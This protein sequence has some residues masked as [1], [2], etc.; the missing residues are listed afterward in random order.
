M[1]LLPG[2]ILHKRYRII[3]QLG[4]GDY[5]VVYRAW[6]VHDE[7]DVAV[8]EYL[9]SRLEV[10]KQF[11]AEARR[12]S[13]LKHPQLPAVRDHFALDDV[14]QYLVSDFVDGVDL[15]TL[16]AQYGPLPSELIIEWLQAVC[17]PL[18]YLHEKGTVHLDVKPA[19]IRLAPGGDVYLVDT[20]LPG[21]GIAPGTG[22]YGSPEQQKQS[23]E[24]GP[25]SDIYSLGATLYTLLTE[26]TPAGALQR[27]AGLQETAAAREVNPDVAPYL[28]IVASR[29][30]SLRADAR[31][32][33]VADF[34]QALQ[35]PSGRPAVQHEALR[36]SESLPAPPPSRQIPTSTRRKMQQRTMWGLLGLL[37]VIL[38]TGVGIMFFGPSPLLGGSDEAAT[39]TTQ[40]QV[41]AALTDVAPT[42]TPTPDPTALPTAT[43]EPVLSETGSRLVFMPGGLFRLGNDQGAEDEQPSRMVSLEP[44]YIDETEVTNGAYARCVAAGECDP[45]A[46]DRASFYPDYYGNPEYDDYPVLYVDWYQ[47]QTFCEWRGDRLPSEAEWERAAGFDPER[48]VKSTYPWG[49]DF[50]GTRLNYCDV[51][52]YRQDSDSA[53]DDEYGDTAPVGSYPAGRSPIGA[54]DMLGNVMEWTN[55][56]YDR[57]YYTVA[58]DTNPLGP[59][60]GFSKSVRGGSWLSM[61]DELRVSVRSFYDPE[62]HRA[63]IGFRCAR[64]VE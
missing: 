61:R 31:F 4:R 63:N 21:L 45:P 40:S 39:A 3:N 57:N 53:Y 37:A 64:S 24:V 35:R 49:D 54:Y 47:A 19:N 59:L 9:D 18:A 36:R 32:E 33:T 48:G 17:Q 7:V 58:P 51:N 14:G 43:P 56:W 41:I 38:V 25:A 12:L 50:D 34:S 26:K 1:P 5:G 29:A 6:D 52:C 20:G 46:T 11:R 22:G 62:E 16:L 30:M 60:E 42:V 44:Y 15:Q 55:D 8:K 28:S 2:E 13:R 23:E 27:E 10:Q